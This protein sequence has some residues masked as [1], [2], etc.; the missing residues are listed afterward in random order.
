MKRL[1]T[2]II[3]FLAGLSVIR[4]QSDFYTTSG[5]EMIFSFATIDDNGADMESI[6]RWAPVFNPQF[7][8]NYDLNDNFGLLFGAAVRNVGFIYKQDDGTKKKHRNYNI[9]IPVGIKIGNMNKVFIYGGYEI[10]F[11]INY[12]EK[13]FVN[14]QKSKFNVW[15]SDRV[16]T[17]Y[18]SVFAGVQFPYGVSLKFKYYFTGFFNQNYTENDGTKPYKGLDV[19][20]FYFSLSTSLFRGNQVYV[21]EYKEYY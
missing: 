5:G 17:I 14:E 4:A 19:N 15:F 9:G 8:A 13:T 10:E 1:T 16:P 12:K 2:L 3:I 11:P 21:K 7:F 20:V 18:N 6:M